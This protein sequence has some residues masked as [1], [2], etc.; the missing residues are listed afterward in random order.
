MYN[1]YALRRN[2]WKYGQRDKRIRKVQHIEFELLAPDTVEEIMTGRQVLA[3]ASAVAWLRAQHPSCALPDEETLLQLGR[4]LLEQR[5]EALEGLEILGE[6]MEKGRRKVRL[7][8]V[9]QAY[10]A[11]GDMVRYYAVNQLMDYME[12]HPEQ[13]VGDM[14]EALEGRRQKE[15]VNMGG[16]LM[17]Q[18]DVNRLRADI[19]S[20]VLG[21]WTAIHHR[22][23]R[24]WARYPLDKQKHAL[25][26]WA[27][28]EGLETPSR[29]DWQQLLKQGAA[30]QQFIYDQV[31]ITRRKDYDNYFRRSTFR[32]EEEMEACIGTI[33]SNTFIIQVK[34]QTEVFDQR[35]RQCLKRK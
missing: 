27:D 16:Q 21:S 26:C 25:A 30:I 35:I 12:A 1:M 4:E 32:N 8:K 19:R 20:G 17:M 28:L 15:W 34:E 14:L 23:D 31:Y 6:R 18:R 13:S 3:R 9:P 22:Y 29:A 2:A 10:R 33:D 24:L 5:P 11:Y 7:L